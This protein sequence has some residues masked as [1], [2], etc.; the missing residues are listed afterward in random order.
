MHRFRQFIRFLRL[1]ELPFD[2]PELPTWERPP[3]ASSRVRLRVLWTGSQ[4][5][6][7]PLLIRESLRNRDRR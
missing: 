3:R 4:V 5:A 6:P 7:V 1:F 2:E